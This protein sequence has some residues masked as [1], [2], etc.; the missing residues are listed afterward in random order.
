MLT[1]LSPHFIFKMQT[2]VNAN[3]QGHDGP[4][5]DLEGRACFPNSIRKLS[6]FRNCRLS[7][8]AAGSATS[9]GETKDEDYK[10]DMV[11][12]CPGEEHRE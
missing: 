7:L 1:V 5:L 4:A 3:N 8:W 10:Q 12:V 6:E 9:M 11:C 2:S